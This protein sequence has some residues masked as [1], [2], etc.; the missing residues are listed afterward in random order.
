MNLQIDPRA[1]LSVSVVQS[2]KTPSVSRDHKQLRESAREFEA[3]YVFEMYKSMRKN[4]PDGG[5]IEKP[6]SSKIFEEMLDME[7]ARKAAAGQGMGLGK[8][9]Y[10]QLKKNV[11]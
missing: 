2:P 4:V 6:S 5:L 9:M 3:M 8:A 1:A 11:K 7:M 10:E